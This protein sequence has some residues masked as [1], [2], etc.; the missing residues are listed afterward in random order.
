[1]AKIGS[2]HEPRH[3]YEA[4]LD[5]IRQRQDAAYEERPRERSHGWQAR[6]RSY[7]QAVRAEVREQVRDARYAVCKAGLPPARVAEY[8]RAKRLAHSASIRRERMA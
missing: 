4:K 3:V 1:M 5:A 2:Y 6:T 7:E 8:V